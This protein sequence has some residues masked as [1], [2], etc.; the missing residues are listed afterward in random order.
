MGG[1]FC[2]LANDANALFWN[3]A[4]ISQIKQTQFVS[5]G[6]RL[7]GIKDFGLGS[8]AL[9]QPTKLGSFGAGGETFGPSL[10][11]ETSLLASYSR[12]LSPGFMLG[13]NIRWMNL[14]IK[15]YDSDYTTGIDIGA[16]ARVNKDLSIGFYTRNINNAR[17]GKDNEDLPQFITAGFAFKPVSNLTLTGDVYHESKF[18]TEFHTGGEYNIS[19]FLILRSGIQT[20]PSRFA[21]GFG[22]R[23]W[24]MEFDYGYYTHLELGATHGISLNIKFGKRVTREVEKPKEVININTASVQELRKL[25]GIGVKTAAEIIKYRKE[26]GGFQTIEEIMEVPGIGPD[27]FDK[28]KEMITVK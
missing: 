21:L 11:K 24:K 26:H 3:P 18:E 12:E 20:N 7:F 10:Y 19:K 6:T 23:Y 16:L 4:G 14:S 5:Y 22:I 28:I 13:G 9:T 8:F 25:P 17:I 1:A 2:A 15:N 27:K